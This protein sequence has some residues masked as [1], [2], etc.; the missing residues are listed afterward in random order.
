MRRSTALYLAWLIASIGL[1]GSLY[2]SEIRH[3][4][5]CKI[6][7]YQRICLFP[8]ALQYAIAC[9]Q[10]N[11]RIIPYVLPQIAVGFLLAV[12]QILLQTFPGHFNLD[13]CND[14]SHNCSATIDIGLGFLSLPWLSAAAFLLI[15]LLSLKA[16]QK[17][18]G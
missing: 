17:K 14:G 2:Y 5:P 13:L 16:R 8:I 9:W 4:E 12:Y 18:S 11:T 15:F 1:F 10:G 3:L 7:W 6:C